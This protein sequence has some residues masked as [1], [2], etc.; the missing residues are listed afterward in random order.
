MFEFLR[1]FTALVVP[2]L[3]E[4]ANVLMVGVVSAATT[5]RM[6]ALCGAALV[7]GG[8][9]LCAISCVVSLT[10]GSFLDSIYLASFG[11]TVVT[12][13]GLAM[14]HASVKDYH[15]DEE[16]EE[17]SSTSLVSFSN[18]FAWLGRQ[19]LVV[20]AFITGLCIEIFQTS[21]LLVVGMA[22][23]SDHMLSTFAGASSAHILGKTFM[24]VTIV[25]AGYLL[26]GAVKF[27]T[28]KL[29]EIRPELGGRLW[30]LFFRHQISNKRDQHLGTGLYSKN[31]KLLSQVCIGILISGFGIF[32]LLTLVA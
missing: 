4:P 3:F 14:L 18:A 9:V 19:H 12:C 31:V 6:R 28:A 10:L 29:H 1:S 13:I 26:F 7:L 21:A 17:G 16:K 20:Q 27:I 25:G 23:S 15:S 24:L 22:A 8:V 11:A 32:Q 30:I 5:L 2:E